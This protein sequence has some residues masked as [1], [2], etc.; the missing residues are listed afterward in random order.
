M[1][2]PTEDII[3]QLSG[4][5]RVG[6]S[7]ELAT[8][9][10]GIPEKTAVEWLTLAQEAYKADEDNLYHDFY[11]AI[12]VASAQAEVIA[13]QRLS[14]EGGAAGAK[15]VL[16]IVNPDKYGKQAVK[17]AK[18]KGGFEPWGNE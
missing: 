9:A 18:A 13:L 1:E 10:C 14:A 8:A 2:N 5:M 3:S 17:K 15:T 12:R 6:A 11:E 16:E 4:Y 7:Y